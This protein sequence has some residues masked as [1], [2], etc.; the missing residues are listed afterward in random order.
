MQ[1]L[2]I[3]II[4]Y[5][6]MRPCY[7]IQ[8]NAIHYNTIYPVPTEVLMYYSTYCPFPVK[9]VLAVMH[10]NLSS[11]IVI[12]R[13]MGTTPCMRSPWQSDQ[14]QHR[15]QCQK[16][17][18]PHKQF[19]PILVARQPDRSCRGQRGWVRCRRL[20]RPRNKLSCRLPSGLLDMMKLR[21]LDM[22]LVRKDSR[23]QSGME[24]QCRMLE[25]ERYMGF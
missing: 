4:D 1:T 6:L 5:R 19:H 23:C 11:S 7:A 3:I 18:H 16:S 20:R 8:Y 25:E 21:P 12:V 22:E 24:Q 9:V 14:A 2:G 17:F 13:S 10:K 15:H